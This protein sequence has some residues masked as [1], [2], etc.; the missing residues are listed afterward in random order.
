MRKFLLLLIAVSFLVVGNAQLVTAQ[1]EWGVVQ[2]RIYEDGRDF[3]RVVLEVLSDTEADDIISITL[4]DPDSDPVPGVELATATRA[5]DW[6]VFPAY[7]SPGYYW[8]W[9]PVTDGSP[10]RYRVYFSWDLYDYTLEEG[11]YEIQAVFSGTGLDT[12][13]FQFTGYK[14]LPVVSL[15]QDSGKEKTKKE[16]D[17]GT[18]KLNVEFLD[19]DSMVLRWNAKAVPDTD[20]S[21]RAYIYLQD[22]GPAQ[23]DVGVS[24]K[25]PTQMGML[26]VPPDAINALQCNVHY[27]GY[28]EFQVQ[29]RFDDNSVR[30][31][32]NSHKYYFNNTPVCP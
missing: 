26:I 23:C 3:T 25:Q 24:I 30:T 15:L 32:S 9:T 31:Y 13:P 14:D 8:D 27:Q 28:F 5:C 22:R 19:D 7:R 16:K 20:T 2:Q 21:E 17:D 18:N 10:W 12:Y 11:V 4:L 6:S 1:I 29:L